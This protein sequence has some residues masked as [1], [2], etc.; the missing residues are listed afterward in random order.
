VSKCLRC[1]LPPI[2]LLLVLACARPPLAD[3]NLNNVNHIV[4]V[5]QENH[6][7][8]N[9]FGALPYAP[10][11]PY[12]NGNGAC[13]STDHSCVDGL[14]CRFDSAGNL[15]CT[16]SNL[17]DGSTV[18]AFHSPTRCVTPDLDHSWVGTHSEVN[19]ENPNSTLKSPL[20]DGF[21]RQNDLTEQIDGNE[22]STDDSTIS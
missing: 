15:N 20:N 1:S 10:G 7:F 3:G 19:F 4:I 6:S 22:T 13:S 8:D 5:M 17:D 16:N 18:V 9:Y 2:A 11:S 14:T 12:H 21:I